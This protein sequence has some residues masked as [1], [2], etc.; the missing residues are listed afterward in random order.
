[1]DE[2]YRYSSLTGKNYNVFACA[3]IVNIAQAMA[4]MDNNV[5]PVDIKISRDRTTGKRCLAFYFDRQESRE[6]YDKWCKYE[7]K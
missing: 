5:Y 6:V 7:L 4:Y 2:F 1:M 3:C